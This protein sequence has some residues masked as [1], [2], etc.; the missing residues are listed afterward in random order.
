MFSK[1]V[2]LG[3]PFACNQGSPYLKC[4]FWLE[5]VLFLLLCHP[6]NNQEIQWK[7][8]P[9]DSNSLSSTH[10]PDRLLKPTHTSPCYEFAPSLAWRLEMLEKGEALPLGHTYFVRP[11]A[12]SRKLAPDLLMATEKAVSA[13][14]KAG[15]ELTSPDQCVCSQ[16]TQDICVSFLRLLM[17]IQ[18]GE[19]KAPSSPFSPPNCTPAILFSHALKANFGPLPILE[20]DTETQ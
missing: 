4:C 5:F 9:L 17:R 12:A 13:H 1:P 18:Y 15:T 16:R 8:P 3:N 19:I 10:I 14:L 2:L 11:L 20:T 6:F 7:A